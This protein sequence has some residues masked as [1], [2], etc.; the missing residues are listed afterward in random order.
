MAPAQF[1]DETELEALRLNAEGKFAVAERA[2][3][4]VAIVGIH[5]FNADH[6]AAAPHVADKGPLHC[7]L[8]EAGFEDPSH[9]L[10]VFAKVL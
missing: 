6:E 7:Q 10:G 1:H 2:I 3:E 4:R 5:D 8:A 9:P